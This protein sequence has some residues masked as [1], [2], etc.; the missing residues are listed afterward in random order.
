[1]GSRLDKF[2][3]ARKAV[4]AD[5]AMEQGIAGHQA[6]MKALGHAAGGWKRTADN[7]L[8]YTDTPARK[9]DSYFEPGSTNKGNA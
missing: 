9:N 7:S 4:K 1:M 8:T 3:R 2:V 6:A 5:R